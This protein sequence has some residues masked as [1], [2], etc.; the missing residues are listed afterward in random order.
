[1]LR[2]RHRSRPIFQRRQVRST[3]ATAVLCAR[4]GMFATRDCSAS[5]AVIHFIR[6]ENRVWLIEA[7]RSVCR[8]HETTR[9]VGAPEVR[10]TMDELVDGAHGSM[11]RADRP[12][13]ARA[14]DHLVPTRSEER[15]VGKECR[16]RWWPCH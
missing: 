6:C 14:P 12:L 8:T 7:G 11:I 3:M 5:Y 13:A 16:S 4:C 15:R 9:A 2:A 1:M 10:R